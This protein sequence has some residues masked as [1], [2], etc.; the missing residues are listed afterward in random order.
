MNYQVF[1]NKMRIGLAHV[2]YHH[3]SSSSSNGHETVR[4]VVIWAKVS[5]QDLTLVDCSQIG[6][7][8]ATAAAESSAMMSPMITGIPHY[9]EMLPRH[10]IPTVRQQSL[11]A[12]KQAPSSTLL[13]F[14]EKVVDFGCCQGGSIH[15]KKVE[16]YNA[17]DKEVKETCCSVVHLLLVYYR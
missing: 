5:N 6:Q 13:Y 17:T 1:G 14:K 4:D 9:G 16:L 15:R 11:V 8:I 7:Q 10:Q 12:P 2:K 3:N